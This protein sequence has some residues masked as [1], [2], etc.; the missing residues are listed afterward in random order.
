MTESLRF[1]R[2]CRSKRTPS[3]KSVMNVA[4]SVVSAVSDY[5]SLSAM[6]TSNRRDSKTE[7]YLFCVLGHKGTKAP[8]CGIPV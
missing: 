8:P 2:D 7:I 4:D 6:T 1:Q 5:Q 3:G